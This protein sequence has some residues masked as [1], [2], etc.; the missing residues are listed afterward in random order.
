MSDCCLEPFFALSWFLTW[1]AHELDELP[2]AARL[3]D[4]FLATH[5]LMP[6]YLGAV[7]M[8]S[9]RASL[10]A[11]EDMPK[12]HSTLMNLKLV[13]VNGDGDYEGAG[14]RSKGNGAGG[15]SMG[16][17]AGVV[18]LLKELL[19]QAEQLWL[20]K[21][22]HELVP[23]RAVHGSLPS[24][25]RLRERRFAYGNSTAAGRTSGRR[26]GDMGDG[27]VAVALTA[28]VAH[29]ARMEGKPA[30]WK[31]PNTV[32]AE[33][34]DGADGDGENPGRAVRARAHPQPGQQRIGRK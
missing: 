4:F 27:E 31:V 34:P 10:L 5:P 16:G 9:Q 24:Q 6:L 30:L 23:L 11:C 15:T 20:A 1:W 14:R 33:W 2:T 8:R 13:A 3:F 29:A 17:M 26:D 32:P 22:P 12:L 25:Q 18:V 21:P 19:R 28:C 7:A